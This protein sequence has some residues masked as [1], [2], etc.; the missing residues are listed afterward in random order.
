MDCCTRLAVNKIQRI[1]IAEKRQKGLQ[2]LDEWGRNSRKGKKL[3]PSAVYRSLRDLPVEIPLHL[4]AR[5]NRETVRKQI[6]H[7]FTHLATVK[8]LINGDDLKKLGIP[9][10]PLF[11]EILDRILDAR[12]DGE[13]ESREDELRMVENLLS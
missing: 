6:S 12:L 4:M 3:L 2:L 8:I 11:R 13:V 5:T 9:D 1:R 10:G 7:Y